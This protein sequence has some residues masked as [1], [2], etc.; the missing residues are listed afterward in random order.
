MCLSDLQSPQSAC[1]LAGL[2]ILAT[3]RRIFGKVDCYMTD[4]HI[5]LIG[6]LQNETIMVAEMR[7]LR[8][9]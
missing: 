8:K 9:V 3:C 2:K 6:E 1:L 5:F 4:V 7:I